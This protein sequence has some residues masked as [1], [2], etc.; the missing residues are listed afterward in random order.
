MV[1]AFQPHLNFWLKEIFN[2][3]L[4]S[5]SNFIFTPP[6]LHDTCFVFSY[7]WVNAISIFHIKFTVHVSSVMHMFKFHYIVFMHFQWHFSE[8]DIEFDILSYCNSLTFRATMLFGAKKFYLKYLQTKTT[9]S[10]N[11]TILRGSLI[12]HSQSSGLLNIL[13]MK[14]LVIKSWDQ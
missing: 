9:L 7:F 6:I 1:P 12:L 3:I 8:P 14:D 5:I 2:A 4:I 13:D 10:R 11:I